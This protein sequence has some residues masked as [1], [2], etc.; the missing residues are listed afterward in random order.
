MSGRQKAAAGGLVARTYLTL[1]NVCAGAA[2]SCILAQIVSALM[3]GQSHANVVRDTL[4][5]LCVVQTAALLEI[6]HAAW[7]LVS[8]PIFSNML[9]VFSRL[10]AVWVVCVCAKVPPSRLYTVMTAAWS[11]ADITRYVYYASN[12]VFGAPPKWLLWC[13]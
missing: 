8:S 12:V 7:G 1:Y 10:V 2:W 6:V 3:R 11:V 13:R 4:H 9:Q 5:P